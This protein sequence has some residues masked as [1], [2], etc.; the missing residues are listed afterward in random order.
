M[1]SASSQPGGESRIEGQSSEAPRITALPTR[2]SAGSAGS[3]GG[4]SDA[5]HAIEILR[6]RIDEEFRISE[7]YD[8]KARQLFTLAAGFFA[9]VQAVA[10]AAFGSEHLSTG[11]RIT[12]LAFTVAAGA[13]L[14]IVGHR[15]ANAE[16]P[17]K[18]HDVPPDDL[19]AWL[20]SEETEEEVLLRQVG[21]LATVA[22]KRAKGNVK[23]KKR[24]D[25][26]EQ[27]ARWSLIVSGV[28]LLI[29]LAV[30]L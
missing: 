2:H 20:E 30:R 6:G 8:S 12:V 3:G 28:E 13:A 21:A 1:S 25:D 15:L 24:Y 19:I 9:A 7:R 10:F 29:A 22:K 26:L 14:V 17:L 27:A 5:E 18:E 11:D 16:A 23:R 4:L